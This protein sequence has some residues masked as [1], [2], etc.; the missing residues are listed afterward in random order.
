MPKWSTIAVSS[1]SSLGL[2]E[3][4]QN[5]ICMGRGHNSLP[6]Y[7]YS[8]P[9]HLVTTDTSKVLESQLA[10]Q[11]KN[12]QNTAFGSSCQDLYFG[13]KT[14]VIGLW[15]ESLTVADQWWKKE[16][17]W[18]REEKC[19]QQREGLPSKAPPQVWQAQP[20]PGLQ[21]WQNATIPMTLIDCFLGSV[22][23]CRSLAFI[24]INAYT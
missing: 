20:M 15:Q 8:L 14:S 18:G 9:L 19:Q 10:S 4:R 16:S 2:A 1:S 6:L 22:K 5:G 7:R 12:C 3:R 23:S 17:P 11:R 24:C 21:M 13:Q